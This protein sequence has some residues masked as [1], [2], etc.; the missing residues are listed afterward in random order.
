MEE[1]TLDSLIWWNSQKGPSDS[2]L[3]GRSQSCPVSWLLPVLG[4]LLMALLFCTVLLCAVRF[5]LTQTYNIS[6]QTS[7]QLLLGD[8]QEQEDTDDRRHPENVTR[9]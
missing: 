8:Y 2:G 9:C 5:M 1:N 4:P 3:A 7:N 6:N